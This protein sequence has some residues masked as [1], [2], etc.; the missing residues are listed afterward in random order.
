MKL[1]VVHETGYHYDTPVAQSTQLLRLTPPTILGQHVLAWR[2]DVPGS[3]TESLDAYGN[4]VHLLTLEGAHQEI[5][6]RAFGTVE[7][8]AC[9]VRP[10]DDLP[11]LLFQRDTALTTASP[12]LR[13]FA[14]D[15]VSRQGPL[16]DTTLVDLA[17]AILS[18]MPF[19]A[20]VTHVGSTAAEAWSAGWGVCQDHTQV[21][22][23]LC[24]AMGYPARYVSGYV[25]SPGHVDQHIASHAWAEVFLGEAWHSLDVVN[26]CP[27]GADHIRLAMGQDYLDAC[28]IRGVRRGGSGE[29]MAAH[30]LVSA[31]D[32]SPQDRHLLD[33]SLR[34]T[35]Q[36]QQQQQ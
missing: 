1:S 18:A 13:A 8:Q 3:V 9:P 2:L 36:Q 14:Q 28:P 33:R 17:G 11:V 27:A 34:R 10:A 5:R 29:L 24:R 4:W 19:R 23:A 25:F 12:E 31:G 35:L 30:A 15:F 22:I 26:Q 20:G 6:I 16:T 7:T 32:P 21:L